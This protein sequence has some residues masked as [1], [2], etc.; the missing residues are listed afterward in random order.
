MPLIGYYAQAT[1]RVVTERELTSSEPQCHE[2][3]DAMV[4]MRRHSDRFDVDRITTAAARCGLRSVDAGCL[5]AGHDWSDVVVMVVPKTRPH[6]AR[7][8]AVVLGAGN[9]R[10]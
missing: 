10:P 3:I 5:P 4:V 8:D 7:F 2:P 6:A 9:K 1:T